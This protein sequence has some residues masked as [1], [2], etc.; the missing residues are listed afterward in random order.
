M[1]VPSMPSPSHQTGAITRG[2]FP[3]APLLAHLTWASLRV[4]WLAENRKF[5]RTG[6]LAVL[7]GYSD[8]LHDGM[9]RAKGTLTV[10]PRPGCLK[11]DYVQR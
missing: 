6:S 9:G 10:I 2:L 3:T 1:L 8:R 5:E 4:R 11:V 7:S